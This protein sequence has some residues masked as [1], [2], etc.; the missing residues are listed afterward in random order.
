MCNKQ[1]CEKHAPLVD[2]ITTIGFVATCSFDVT[3]TA[4][5][6]PTISCPGHVTVNAAAD[7]CDAV[8]NYDAPTTENLCDG[9]TVS[10]RA[11][12]SSGSQF[13]IGTMI[14]TFDI[15]DASNNVAGNILFVE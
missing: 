1:H 8:V 6:P 7:R 11:G 9:Q 4:D 2:H 14:N 10:Q 5:D 15:V 13:P 12:Q 3:V